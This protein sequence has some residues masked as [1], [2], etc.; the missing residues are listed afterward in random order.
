MAKTP[1]FTREPVEA[2]PESERPPMPDVSKQPLMAGKVMISPDTRAQLEAVGWEEGD[3]VPGNLG[4]KIQQL[5]QHIAQDIATAGPDVAPDQP[6][7]KPKTMD[8]RDLPES[9]R[10]E[11]KDFLQ[12]AKTLETTQA[13]ASK[14]PA[15]PVL[16]DAGMQQAAQVA[17]NVIQ[18]GPQ[19]IVEDDS[20]EPKRVETPVPPEERTAAIEAER[21]LTTAYEENTGQITCPRCLWDTRDP[22]DIK[23]TELDKQTYLAFML[24]DDPAARFRKDYAIMGGNLVIRFRTLSA[25]EAEMMYGQLT[26]DVQANLITSDGDYFLRMMA[27]RTMLGTER[28][29]AKGVVQVEIPPIMEIDY[30]PGDKSR[31]EMMTEWF[32]TDAIPSETR[33][34]ILN[35]HH[36][37]FQRLVEGLEVKTDEADFWKGIEPLSS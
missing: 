27:Y 5:Q 16:Q 28:I 37:E 36:R 20:A 33:R 19:A 35:Q 34:R 1:S 13:A 12:Q 30:T 23:F 17:A 4:E 29:V 25:V 10:Q 11:I 26:N 6:A 24:S 31:I 3:P 15:M 14:M 2:P 7:L 18:Q 9:H 8:I 22:F 32:N 21:Q